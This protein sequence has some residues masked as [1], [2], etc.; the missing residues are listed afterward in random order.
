MLVIV[1]LY[2]SNLSYGVETRPW[3]FRANRLAKLLEDLQLL[4]LTQH[5]IA[6]G[7]ALKL[8]NEFGFLTPRLLLDLSG[9]PIEPCGH[10]FLIST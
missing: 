1:L 8:Q 2:R 9:H 3:C 4:L 6:S 10:L 5:R 7:H